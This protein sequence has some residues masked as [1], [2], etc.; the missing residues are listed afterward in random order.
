MTKEEALNI[1]KVSAVVGASVLTGWL[2]LD[3][4]FA[5]AKDVQ[6]MQKQYKV[7]QWSFEQTQNYIRQDVLEDRLYR[8]QEQAAPDTHKVK[9]LQGSIGTLKARSVWLQKLQDTAD[10]ET[11]GNLGITE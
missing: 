1:M 2:F 6:S 3:S 10:Q 5:H 11:R 8:E 4:Y 9:K 7:D